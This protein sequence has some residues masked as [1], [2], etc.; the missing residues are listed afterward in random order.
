[1]TTQIQK[2]PKRSSRF[3]PLRLPNTCYYNSIQ[4]NNAY[5][6]PPWNQA[7]IFIRS[8]SVMCVTLP[9]G[10]AFSVTAC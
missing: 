2:S 5:F 7:A 10:I 4:L 9:S 8:S 3:G 6:A 1:M